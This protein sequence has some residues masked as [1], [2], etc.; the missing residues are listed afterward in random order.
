ME[1]S[2]H[3]NSDIRIESL[4]DHIYRRYSGIGLLSI[5]TS[6]KHARVPGVS[7]ITLFSLNPQSVLTSRTG[8]A[9]D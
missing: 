7:F 2:S 4:V 1:T 6:D 9:W 5:W 8:Q 3:A